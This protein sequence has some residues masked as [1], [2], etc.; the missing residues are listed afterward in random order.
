MKNPQ[1][2]FQTLLHQRLSRRN[3]LKASS[4]LGGAAALS[5]CSQAPLSGVLSISSE[6]PVDLNGLTF[7]EVPHGLDE[8]LTVAEGYDYQVLVRWGDPIF[9]DAPQFDP[10]AQ[11]QETQLAQFGFNNDFIGFVPFSLSA[12]TRAD[13]GEKLRDDSGHGLLVVNHEYTKGRLMHPDL[14]KDWEMDEAQTKV[15]IAAHGLSVLEVKQHDSGWEVVKSSRFNRRITPNTPMQFTGAAAGASRMKTAYSTD[16]IKTRGTYGNCA[17]GVTPWGTIL[18]AEENIDNYFFGD[19]EALPEKE[20][21]ARFG[22]KGKKRKSWG[23]Y[24]PRWDLDKSPNEGLH[25]GWIVEIDP[26]DPH[27]I[28][29][30]RTSLGRCK[31]EGCNIHITKNNHVVAYTGDDQAFEYVY[32][33]VSKHQYQPGDSLEARKA[34]M[35]LLDEGTLFVARLFDDGRLQWLPLVYGEGPLTQANGF[36]SQA[37]VLIDTRKAADLLEAT[38]MDRPEDVEVNPTNGKVYVMLTKNKARQLGDIE[39]GNPR[40]FN[41]GGQVI[42]L[43]APGGDHTADNFTWE[44]FM[45]GGNPDDVIAF[46]NAYTPKQSW[47]ACP[48]NCAFDNRGNIWIATDGAEDFGV[49]DGLWAAPTQGNGRALPKRILRTPKGAELCGPYFSPDNKTLF[50]SIQHPGGDSS[51]SKPDTRWPDFDPTMPPRPAVVAITKKD[52]GVIG[53]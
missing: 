29:K 17:G 47:L 32:K 22:F 37:D 31:H 7:K 18:T 43:I 49:A 28:P 1:P 46:Y 30:K 33:F 11:T 2:H 39:P 23:R 35:R 27:S 19:I 15:D 25:M 6:P 12:D 45:L 51:F 20:S 36:S 44:L 24:F 41:R 26:F 5:A 16:G 8:T 21:Y 3:L 14:D 4:A 13:A 10:L 53:S 50:C 38:P 9:D 52:G 34:N 48:D 40:A 42:E